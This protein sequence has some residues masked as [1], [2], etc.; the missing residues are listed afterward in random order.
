MEH[1]TEYAIKSATSSNR[2]SLLKKVKQPIKEI[3]KK[4]Y[5]NG[6]FVDYTLYIAILNYKKRIMRFSIIQ[7]V[8]ELT[9]Y[10]L[11]IIDVIN[12]NKSIPFTLSVIRMTV[13]LK[14]V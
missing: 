14:I 7:G 11:V 1:T 3:Q 5:M 8:L 12:N 9:F 4:I 13:L 10:V 6:I 2:K